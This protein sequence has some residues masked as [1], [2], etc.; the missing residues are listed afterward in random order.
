M[1]A[2]GRFYFPV[3]R[4]TGASPP[5][6]SCQSNTL[7]KATAGVVSATFGTLEFGGSIFWW[8]MKITF[9]SVI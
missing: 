9:F 3:D 6:P 8:P 4:W 2:P 1:Q 7:V 5:P